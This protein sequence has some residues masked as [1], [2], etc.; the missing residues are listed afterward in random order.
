MGALEI[1]E[2]SVPDFTK[3]EIFIYESCKKFQQ[4]FAY[5]S[6]KEIT[7]SSDISQAALTRFAKKLGYKGFI[8]FQFALKQDLE[9]EPEDTDQ[10]LV[11]DYY[12]RYMHQAEKELGK[13]DLH[14]LAQRILTSQ[15]IVLTGFS[16]SHMPAEYLFTTMNILKK[17]SQ[18]TTIEYMPTGL[19]SK[20]LLMIYSVASGTIYI[21]YLK[22]LYQCKERPYI[23]LVTMHRQHPLAG[24]ADEIIVLPDSSTKAGR[25]SVLTE[26][27]GFFLFDDLLSRELFLQES[28]KRV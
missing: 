24:Y 4:M 8:E 28:D 9:K 15:N 11:S 5:G 25:K 19:G 13:Y 27:L 2:K 1:M 16:L 18:C 10:E 21:Q 20:D 3:N 17:P 14:K 6:I 23:V 7:E 12:G 22:R 26:S